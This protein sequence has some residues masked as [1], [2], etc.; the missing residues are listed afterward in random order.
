MIRRFLK[1]GTLIS[2][3]LLLASVV[4]QITARFLLEQAPSWTEETSRLFFIYSTAFAAGLALRDKYYVHLDLFFEKLNPRVQRILLFIIPSMTLFLFGIMSIYSI[5]FILLGHQETSPSMGIRMSFVFL[6]LF[7]M[8]A[9]LAYYAGVE[10]WKIIKDR[11][12]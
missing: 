5:A 9:S 10:I 2:T 7:I 6:S 3:Y 4:L 8:S 11:K 12:V 1:Y